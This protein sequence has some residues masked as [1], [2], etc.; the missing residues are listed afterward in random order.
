MEIN[1]VII[2]AVFLIFS[3][4]VGVKKLTWLLAGY[5]EKKVKDKNKLAR[6]VGITLALLGVVLLISGIARVKEAEYIMM[7]VV[8]ILLI[9]VVYVNAKMVE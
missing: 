7:S 1:L 2:G 4:L 6:L 3:Y 9:E 5:N 8:A